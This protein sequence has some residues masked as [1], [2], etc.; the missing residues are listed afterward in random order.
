MLTTVYFLHTTQVEDLF[1]NMNRLF[2][3]V[4]VYQALKVL[5]ER[6]PAFHMKMLFIYCEFQVRRV[7][8]LIIIGE[9]IPN[10]R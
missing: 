3:T 1:F 2:G 10:L 4:D 6:M 5:S 7:A 9:Y 8:H